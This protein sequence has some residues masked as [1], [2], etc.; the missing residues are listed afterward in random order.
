M[1]NIKNLYRLKKT[2]AYKNRKLQSSILLKK[3][4]L[5]KVFDP[6]VSVKKDW[7][8]DGGDMAGL[9]RAKDWSKSPLGPLES[10]PQNLRT[11][12]S[13]CLAS[14][15]PINIIWGPDAIQIYNSGYRVICEGAHPHALGESFR[16]TWASAL[17]VIGDAFERARRGETTFFEN[18]R[19]FLFRNGYFEETFFTFSL[20]PIRDENGNVAGI[21][22][23]MTE[24]TLDILNQRRTRLLQDISVESVDSDNLSEAVRNLAL[25]LSDYKSDIPGAVIFLENEEGGFTAAAVSGN[26]KGMVD[27]AKWPSDEVLETSEPYFFNNITERFGEVL[28]SEYNEPVQSA[29]LLPIKI[30]GRQKP[31]GFLGAILSERLPHDE[32]YMAFFDLLINA[33]NLAVAGAVVNEKTAIERYGYQTDIH[34]L[35]LERNSAESAT[36]SKSAFLANMSHEIRTPLAAILGFTEILKSRDLNSEDRDKYLNIIT[37]N[38]HALVRIIDDILDLSKIE[39]GKLHIELEPLCLTELILDVLAMFTDRATGKGLAL[40]F[41]SSRLPEFFIQSDSV[42]IRQILINLIGNA[43]KFTTEGSVSVKGHFKLI[44]GSTYEITLSV[45]DT[46][47]GIS[48]EQS[49]KLFQAFTQADNKTTRHFGGTGLGLALS[50]KLAKAM[51]GNVLIEKSDSTAGT[52]FLVKL[53]CQKVSRRSEDQAT[54]AKAHEKQIE[55]RLRGWS[56]LIVD[57][58]EDNRTLMKIFLERE[59]ALT[60]QASSGEEGIRMALLKDYDSILMDIQMPGLDGYEALA[61]L[62]AENYKKPVFAITAH[63]MKE[64]KDRAFAAGFSGHI[65]KPINPL[66]MV[67]TLIAHTLKLN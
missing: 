14:S 36:K 60:E 29:C 67:D 15:F 28:C 4:N 41:D 18:Q 51:G 45:T 56:V 9:I 22:N 39:A 50:K 43:I 65:S 62:R 55:Q 30:E 21:F 31:I 11:T 25:T 1:I 63:T 61:Q 20:S 33:V 26:V 16:V 12:V 19:L 5:I 47:I 2:D 44:E 58:S 13:L 42:R 27:L 59:G 46:G 32:L 8:S 24:T 48:P 34:D 3:S 57:D 6:K 64:E 35:E 52:T 7:L 66:Q 10:W 49:E 17:S 23:P 53:V 54:V 37:R 38:G 40:N